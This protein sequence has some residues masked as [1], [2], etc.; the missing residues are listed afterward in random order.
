[1]CHVAR[2][3][4]FSLCSDENTKANMPPCRVLLLL[5]TVEAEDWLKLDT[6]TMQISSEPE[7]D[8]SPPHPA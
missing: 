8:S 4:N 6:T 3:N 1:M 7:Q 2:F 5:T